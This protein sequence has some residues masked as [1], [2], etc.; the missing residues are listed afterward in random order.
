MLVEDLETAQDA[1]AGGATVV[2]LRLKDVSTDERVE[3]GRSF[4]ELD[5]TFVVND[6][7]EAAVRLRA[8]GVHLGRGDE[9]AER[10]LGAGLLLG[11]SAAS[12]DE[13][14]EAEARGAGYVGAGPV[15]ATPSK[16]DADP[17][18][19]LDGLRAICRS[20]AIP[21]VAIGGIDASNAR[22]CI[23]AGAAGVA[24]IRAA[25]EAAADSRCDWLTGELGL[26]AELERRGLAR[27]IENDAAVVD[28]LVV[29]QDAL[30]EGVHF[31]LDWLSWRDLGFRAAAVNLSD[32]AA[33]GAE[34]SGLLV[35][36]GAPSETRVEDVLELYEGIAE[37]GVPVVG[38]DTTRADVLMLSV[39]ALGRSDRVPG[40]GGARPG[41]LLV[42]TGPLGAA[43]RGLPRAD[44]RPSAAA[45]RGGA[46][47]G[48]GGGG[49]PRHLGRAGR[50]RRPHRRTLRGA[51]HDR[52]R[53]GAPR[54]GRDGRGSRLRRG[55]RAAGRDPRAGRGSR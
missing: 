25:G 41:D 27:T 23:E 49:R 55:L 34:P 30:V 44:L 40:R 14:V 42:V 13:A 11:L 32:L 12:V 37:T 28:G 18:I 16:A 5:A 8:D 46:R 20:V 33:S 19:G 2:Q 6:D 43:G 3:R 9:G 45:A 52:P 38:G 22:A 26:L 51:V 4:G 47:A 17:P 53:G 29:T 54:R 10:A 21:V 31:L 39:T 15:W 50:R 1:V 7:V 24:V 48:P 36:F 35:S